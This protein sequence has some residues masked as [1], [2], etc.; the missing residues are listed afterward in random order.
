MSESR[1]IPDRL[2]DGCR[3]GDAAAQKEVYARFYGYAMNI[4]LRYA[5]TREVA[6]EVLNDGFFKVFKH[7][8]RYNPA[9]PFLS[10]FRRIIV[11]TAIDHFR[12]TRKE[13]DMLELLEEG[14]EDHSISMP[15]L[16]PDMDPLPILQQLS[17]GYRMVFNLY[18]MEEYSHEEIGDML[19]ITPSASRSNLT[20]A[21][22]RL[23]ELMLAE[24]PTK[25]HQG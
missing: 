20:R 19:G 22:K 15:S 1:T 25:Q 21:K 4:T 13:I 2:L 5:P 6:T 16:D 23:R 18:V 9:F 11:N 12:S 10:W 7:M 24:M 3:R 8:D 17:P 14:L